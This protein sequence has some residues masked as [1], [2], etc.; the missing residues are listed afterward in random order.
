MTPLPLDNGAL[1]L[2][3]PKQNGTPGSDPAHNIE[4]TCYAI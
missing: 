1:C 4:N 3:T 2:S